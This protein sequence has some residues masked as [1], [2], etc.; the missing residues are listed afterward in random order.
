MVEHVCIFL[1]TH[2]VHRSERLKQTPG[3][4]VPTNKIKSHNV[5]NSSSRS[6]N[7]SSN[8]AMIAYHM[9]RMRFIASQFD[10]ILNLDPDVKGQEV[11]VNLRKIVSY[12]K[13]AE[14]VIGQV[15]NVINRQ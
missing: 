11:K 3:H 10:L 7:V 12:A 5:T 4:N 13:E 1:E 9:Q 14:N 6:D 8:K 15:V 2:N